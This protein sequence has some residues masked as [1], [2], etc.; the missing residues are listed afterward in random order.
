M[1]MSSNNVKIDKMSKN[2][3]TFEKPKDKVVTEMRDKIITAIE[4]TKRSKVP[5]LFFSNPGYGK[6]TTIC[7][8]A[9]LMGMHVEELIGSQYSQDEILGFQSRTNKSYLEVLEPEW[10]HRITT[11]AEPHYE[12]ISSGNNFTLVE[13]EDV[14]KWKEQLGSSVEKIN[15]ITT[16]ISNLERRLNELDGEKKELVE[17][18]LR[19]SRMELDKAN[20]NCRKYKA[21]LDDVEWRAPRASILFLDELSTASPNVQGAILNLCFNRKIRGNKE[22]PDDCII[23]SAANYKANLTGFNEIISPQL[24]RF[25]LVNILPG[26]KNSDNTRSSYENLGFNI[27]DEFLQDFKEVDLPLPTFN[28]DFKFDENTNKMF[29]QDLRDELKKIVRKYTGIDT[30]RAILDF[31]NISFDGIYDRNDDIP[32]VYNFMSPRT[33]SYY[34]RIVRAM[35]EMGIKSTQKNLYESFVDGM[36]GLGTNNWGDDDSNAFKACITDFHNALYD[37]TTTLINKYRKNMSE[38]NVGE[39]RKISSSLKFSDLNTITGKVKNIISLQDHGTF[40][41]ADPIVAE[42][43]QQVCKDLYVEN[44]VLMGEKIKGICSSPENVI[45][46]RSDIES[47]KQFVEIMKRIDVDNGYVSYIDALE[48]ELHNWEFYYVELSNIIFEKEEVA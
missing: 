8:Y 39:E 31:R 45:S 11:Y 23:L 26:N 41:P 9:R 6:T 14:Q 34:A 48:D 4:V 5:T 24:N 27:V 1:P 40:T 2:E 10:Y 7:S 33:M 12:K 47:L 20:S 25:C 38:R 22:L 32:E 28:N 16:E 35:C 30:S 29:L 37:M 42:L 17:T 13:E 46:F 19:I 3:R 15:S 21:L 44:P 36:F 18:N 43:T